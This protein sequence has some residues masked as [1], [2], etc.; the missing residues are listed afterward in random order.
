MPAAA[1][2]ALALVAH[3][4]CPPANKCLGAMRGCPESR[5]IAFQRPD[6]SGGNVAASREDDVDST[7]YPSRRARPAISPRGPEDGTQ[8]L[9]DRAPGGSG[10][11]RM[12]NGVRQALR[13]LP[14]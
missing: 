11:R 1:G 2:I 9:F 12:D 13:N 14:Q 10:K 6:G 7:E 8:D 5:G 4:N 3:D